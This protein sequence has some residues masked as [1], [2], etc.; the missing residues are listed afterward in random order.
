VPEVILEQ[1][2][3][4]GRLA[5]VIREH[6]SAPGKAVLFQRGK[7]GFSKQYL[8]DAQTPILDEFSK[9]AEFQF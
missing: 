3:D 6:H 9:K 5:T 4:K 1:L 8:F 2:S 7:S